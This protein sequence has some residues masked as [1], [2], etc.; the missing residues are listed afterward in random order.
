MT[1]LPQFDRMPINPRTEATEKGVFYPRWRCFCCADSGFIQ[2]NLIRLIIPDYN[3][4][5]D[6]NVICQNHGCNEFDNKWGNIPLENFDTR[7]VPEI[8]QKL[9]FINRENW[10]KTVQRQV[11]IR[12]LAN[13]L[14]MPHQIYERSANDEREILQSKTEI[15]AYDWAGMAKAYIGGSDEQGRE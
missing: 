13:S 2:L 8:C 12:Q 7:F 10:S 11:E 15:E 3:P 4:H 14:K 6:K 9:D 5:Q 1:N